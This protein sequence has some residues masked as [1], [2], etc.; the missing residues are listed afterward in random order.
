MRQTRWNVFETNSSS[1]HSITICT[2]DEYRE[3]KRGNM[4]LDTY[5]GNLVAISDGMA[6]TESGRYKTYKSMMSQ[7]LDTY[8]EHFITPSGDKMVAFGTYG[9]DG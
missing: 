6:E 1:T 5:E 9:W 3:F 4:A 8:A 2:Q 7:C